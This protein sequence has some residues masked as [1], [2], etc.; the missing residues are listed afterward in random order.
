MTEA[1]Y[2]AFKILNRSM[3]SRSNA[4]HGSFLIYQL[5]SGFTALTIN[6]ILQL[7]GLKFHI[8]FIA[9]HRTGYRDERSIKDSHGS[10]YIVCISLYRLVF[11]PN[12]TLHYT[13]LL[14]TPPPRPQ[15]RRARI[16]GNNIS[17]K[18]LLSKPGHYGY[19]HYGVCSYD[20]PLEQARA[21]Y[22]MISTDS[23]LGRCWHPSAEPGGRGAVA[24]TDDTPPHVLQRKCCTAGRGSRRRRPTPTDALKAARLYEPFTLCRKLIPPCG[25]S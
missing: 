1:L 3:S 9:A 2:C 22:T 12:P 23:P 17:D 15:K 24:R 7:D 11:T 19:V 21:Q 14:F 5:N 18:R 13:T 8:S 4:M 16:T 6:N 25:I 10:E 20:A